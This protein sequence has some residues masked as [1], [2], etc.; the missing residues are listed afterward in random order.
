[1]AHDVF[2]VV[3]HLQGKISEVTFE[4][5]GKGKELA[6]ATG[7]KLVALLM[8]G[9]VKALVGE[10]GAADS[11]LVVDHPALGHYT[12]EAFKRTLVG[13]V[14]AR[15][16]KLVLVANTAMGMDQAA[17]LSAE[18]GIPL[19]AYC[20]EMT[21]ENGRLV[22]VSQVYGG[23]ILAEA[24]VEGEQSVLTVLAGAFPA[25]KGKAAGSPSVEEMAP[26]ASL[27]GLKIRFKRLIQP[28]AGDVDIT[29]EPILVSV[30]RGIQ[31]KD[32]IPIVQ[33]LADALGGA[34]SASRPITDNNWLPKTRQVGKSGM[35]V[36]P[37]LYIAVGISGAPE[38]I[39]GM[40]DA[41]LIVAINTD[42]AAPIF[43]VAHYGVT[44]DLFD[45]VP[46]LTEKI[47]SLKG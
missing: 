7:G 25:D 15:A 14:K 1:M 27:D 18:L 39:E 22:A 8:G 13:V 21:L 3:E 47:K 46:L 33:E 35:S 32:N 36:K 16:P 40:R 34:L 2:V 23:K 42:P 37:K 28:E 20:K 44:A 43:N 38:H 24:D 11:V 12:P 19:V 29:K 9:G 45:V 41:E 6:S 26:P 4:L 30:G 17:G 10:L 31:N 5:L